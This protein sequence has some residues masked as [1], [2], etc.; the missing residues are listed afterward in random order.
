MDGINAAMAEVISFH[1]DG[2]LLIKASEEAEAELISIHFEGDGEPEGDGRS[3]FTITINSE[4]FTGTII[5]E[6]REVDGVSYTQNPVT[7]AG[8]GKTIL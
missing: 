7:L 5:F 8:C 4:S 2:E 6:T 1:L 3:L